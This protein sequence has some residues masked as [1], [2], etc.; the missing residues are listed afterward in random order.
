MGHKR[1]MR[2]LEL[3]IKLQQFTPDKLRKVNQ[4]QRHLLRLQRPRYTVL[5][6]KIRPHLS[7]MPYALIMGIISVSLMFLIRLFVAGS[8]PLPLFL[9]SGVGVIVSGLA[10]SVSIAVRSW[11]AARNLEHWRAQLNQPRHWNWE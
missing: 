11:Q 9:L 7:T 3:E 4:Y 6:D 5:V 2:R 8:L 1:L 10:C